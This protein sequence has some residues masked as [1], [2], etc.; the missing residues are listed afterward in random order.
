MLQ[1]LQVN[2]V[3]FRNAIFKGLMIL[4]A[5]S[6]TRGADIDC[7]HHGDSRLGHIINFLRYCPNLDLEYS[8]HATALHRRRSLC[9]V[10]ISGWYALTLRN[11][12]VRDSSSPRN[13]GSFGGPLV[14]DWLS[15]TA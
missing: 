6:A 12:R 4:P 1:V 3:I 10:G 8:T 11:T 15:A 5:T 2:M 7:D 14:S 9:A 13:S